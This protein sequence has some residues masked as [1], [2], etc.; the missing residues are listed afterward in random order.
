MQSQILPHSGADFPEWKR[1]GLPSGLS[2]QMELDPAVQLAVQLI[3]RMQTHRAAVFNTNL[4]LQRLDQQF[5]GPDRFFQILLRSRSAE[6]QR[7]TRKHNLSGMLQL[8]AHEI[9]DFHPCSGRRK[10]LHRFVIRNPQCRDTSVGHMKTGS[11]NQ[12]SQ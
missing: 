5:P 7:R 8:I 9:K 4:K 11:A 12:T 2:G 10:I 1:I 3:E 6:I